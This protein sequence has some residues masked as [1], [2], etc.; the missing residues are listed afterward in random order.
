MLIGFRDYAEPAQRLADALGLPW[1]EAYVHRFPDG[2]SRVQI[3]ATLPERVIFCRSLHYPNDKLVELVLAADTA[4]QQGASHLTLVAPYLCYMRQDTAFAPGQAV[5]QQIIGKLLARSF[6]ALV[7]VDPHLHRTKDLAQAVPLEHAQALSAAPLM[8]DF[9]EQQLDA[10]LVVGPD[11]ESA[12][13]VASIAQPRGW[14]H[15]VGTKQRHTDTDVE[16]SLPDLESKGRHLVL[17]DDVASTGHTLVAAARELATRQPAS[18]HVLVT[19]G[20][21]VGDALDRLRA[22]GVSKVWSTDSIPHPTN[23]IRLAGLLAAAL[24]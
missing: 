14:D 22:A 21:F 10:P 5:S 9:L 11:E 20:L 19:H 16:V 18:I 3:P 15:A 23:C 2:E 8:A 4:R 12:Q 1:A 7:T 13:W 6:D 24:A 17:V